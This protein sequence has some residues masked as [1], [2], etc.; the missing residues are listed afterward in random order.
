M[1]NRDFP[2]FPV[3]FQWLN[4]TSSAG[5]MGWIPGRGAKIPHAS[6]PKQKQYCNK[7]NKDLKMVHTKKIFFNLLKNNLNKYFSKEDIKMV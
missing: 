4:L 5:G 1:G 7:F 3:V 6:E 2:G